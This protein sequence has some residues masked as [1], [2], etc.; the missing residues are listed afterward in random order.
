[1]SDVNDSSVG[2]SDAKSEAVVF[3]YPIQ[4]REAHLDTFGHVNNAVYL[5][6]FEEARWDAITARGFGLDTIQEKKIGP[7]VLEIKI[8]F[9]KELRL[10]EKLVIRSWTS[11]SSSSVSSKICTMTQ[12]M[13]NE[14]GEEA[15]R[16]EFVFGLF[17]LQKRRLMAPTPEWMHAI[18]LGVAK[19][20]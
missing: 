3:E 20:P 7:V 4:I 6:L 11:S 10:R 12:V 2:K 19:A 13:I 1:V 14:N 18:G 16:A 8:R 17:D 5:E 15:C 9:Q